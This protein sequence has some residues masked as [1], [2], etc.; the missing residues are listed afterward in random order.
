MLIERNEFRIKFG[1][2][3]EALALW[4][5]LFDAFSETK[6]HPKVRMMTDITGPSY[7]LI[8]E[9]QLRSFQDLGFKAYQWHTNQKAHDI[10]L[11]VVP[12]CESC[13]RTLYNLEYEN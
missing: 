9:L 5:S 4:K 6:D 2:M 3:K 13:V 10:Y 8:V 7:T 11:Q 12:L 1:H